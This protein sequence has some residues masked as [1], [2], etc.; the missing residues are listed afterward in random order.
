M[1]LVRRRVVEHREIVQF[2][3]IDAKRAVRKIVDDQTRTPTRALKRIDI[4]L[5]RFALESIGCCRRKAAPAERSISIVETSFSLLYSLFSINP[6]LAEERFKV[7]SMS[8]A[9]LQKTREV[10]F[11]VSSIGHY[12]SLLPMSSHAKTL[13]IAGRGKDRSERIVTK[14]GSAL[15]QVQQQKQSLVRTI[16]VIPQIL[17]ESQQ[18]PRET[19]LF[20]EA[21]SNS[22]LSL[23]LLINQSCLRFNRSSG[24]QI[25]RLFSER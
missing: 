14:L 5:G 8:T 21:K 11:T 9:H 2:S 16:G 18:K 23:A 1:F 22:V 10:K 7:T 12:K 15:V 3:S 24:D 17:P 6:T 19:N 20:L 25:H 4:R 13:S